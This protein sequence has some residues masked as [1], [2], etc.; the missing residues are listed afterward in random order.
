M[1]KTKTKE[2][3]KRLKAIAQRAALYSPP[4][5]AP[6]ISDAMAEVRLVVGERRS[7]GKAL[8]FPITMATAKASPK[9][10][11]RP[12]TKAVKTLS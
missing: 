8:V 12:K 5:M 10:L 6:P 2:M 11:D 3:T 9:A 7:A 4:S 1:I